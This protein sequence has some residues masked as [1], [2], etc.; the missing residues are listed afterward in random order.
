MDL[1]LVSFNIRSIDDPDGN[2]IA[3]RAPRLRSILGAIS[4]DLIGFQENTPA[5]EPL[6]ARDYGDD[7]AVFNKYRCTEGWIESA[8]L[9]WKK[10]RFDEEKRGWFWFSDT[11]DVESGGWDTLGH[12]RMCAWVV[13]I[14][15]A[16]GKR[17]KFMN[18]H[19]GFGEENQIKS[20]RLLL[21]RAGAP[22]RMPLILTGDFNAVPESGAYRELSSVLT[23]VNALTLKDFSRT[24]HGYKDEGGEHIDYCFVNDSV[25][26]LSLRVITDK[27]GGKYPSDHFGLEI[28]LNIK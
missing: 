12:K 8:P 21:E 3:E 24:F 14:E 27:V 11:P 5:W 15:K 6:I 25:R 4:P 26:P 28:G 20:A 23:D 9:L 16:T 17:F 2:S 7:Y 19:F 1:K 22:G 10:E 18:T 13:L